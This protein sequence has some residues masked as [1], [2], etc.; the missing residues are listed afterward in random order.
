MNIGY[1][2]L[3]L[4]EEADGPRL[5][6]EGKIGGLF[7][8][9]DSLNLL[10]L[11]L[12]LPEYDYQKVEEGPNVRFLMANDTIVGFQTYPDDG[13]F[14]R[15]TNMRHYQHLAL[16]PLDL[17]YLMTS[18][19][20]KMIRVEYPEH[21]RTIALSNEQQLQFMNLLRCLGE[22]VGWYPLTP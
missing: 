6:P 20:V 21:R 18:V 2:M 12:A 10:F 1:K 16:V 17:Y 4:Y 22:R 13:Y 7:H 11:V 19:E 15:S 3:S 9:L 5:V 8:E 14:D